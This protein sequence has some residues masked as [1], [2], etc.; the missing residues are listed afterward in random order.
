[1]MKYH[2]RVSISSKPPNTFNFPCST[3]RHFISTCIVP[4]Y[5]E[6]LNCFI[7]RFPLQLWLTYKMYQKKS[8][9]VFNNPHKEQ[10]HNKTWGEF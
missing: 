5:S 4:L 2:N 1:M 10:K 8:P 6:L 9:A 3:K 7:D